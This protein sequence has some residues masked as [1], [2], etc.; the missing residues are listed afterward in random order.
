[1]TAYV[2]STQCQKTGTISIA[3]AGGGT[4]FL[5][6]S[7][8]AAGQGGS[9]Y[10]TDLTVANRTAND[11]SVTFKFLGHDVDGRG[12][13]VDSATYASRIAVR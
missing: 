12:S 4:W 6:S 9:F 3:V 10:T 11:A 5:P 13:A 7:A 2:G 1:L 8:R